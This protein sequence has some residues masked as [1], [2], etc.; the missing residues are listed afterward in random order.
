M[1]NG[2][3]ASEVNSGGRG[4]TAL[5]R[6]A[7][8]GGKWLIPV[9]A[10]AAITLSLLRL[11]LTPGGW[12]SERVCSAVSELG[13]LVPDPVVC[14]GLASLMLIYWGA[15]EREEAAA[16]LGTLAGWLTGIPGMTALV[17]GA[18]RGGVYMFATIKRKVYEQIL[19]DG[20]AQGHSEGRAQGHSEGRVE[21]RDEGV[22][23]GRREML[24]RWEEWNRRR[25]AAEARGE[26][27]EE[28]PPG[29]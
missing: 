27:F 18:V 1:E 2:N 10:L 12:Q 11:N 22:Q 24:R 20:R 6:N 17:H 19:A 14:I 3:G 4:R 25:L 15:R 7:A 23:A 13:R 8:R 28:P 26:R 29:E 5:V 16:L 9:A 21:G